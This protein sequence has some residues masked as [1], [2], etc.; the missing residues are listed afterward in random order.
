L[1]LQ[2]IDFPSNKLRRAIN[3]RCPHAHRLPSAVVQILSRQTS[4]AP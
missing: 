3:A 4:T 1:N 2:V